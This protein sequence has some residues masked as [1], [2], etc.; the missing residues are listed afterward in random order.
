MRQLAAILFADMAGY[1]A[2]MQENEQLARQKRNRLKSV[3]ES[4]V[5][6]HQGQILQYYGDGSLSIFASAINAVQCA[7]SI[8]QQ[9]REAP[10]VDLRIG[11]HTGDV[12]VEDGSI[13]GDGVNLASRVESLAVPGSVFISEKVYDEIRNQENITSHELGYFELKNVKQPV[14]IFAITSG[15]LVIPSRDE[16][17]GKTKQP[18]NRLAVLPFVNMSADAENEYFSD[19]ITEELL[20]ALTKVD[21]LQVTSR[22]S[23]YAFKGKNDDIRDIAVKL[24]VDKVLEGSVRK[25]GSRVRI[26]AQLINAADGYHL[27]S[28]TYDRQL[29]DIFEVQDEIS[30]I[31]AN[32][33]RENLSRAQ[34]ESQ[35]SKAPTQNI[36]AYTAYLQGLHFFNKTTPADLRKSIERFEEALQLEPGYAQAYAMIATAYSQLGA[37]GQLTPHKA[38]ALVH[39]YAAKALQLDSSIA[40]IYIAEAGA[41]LFYEWKWKETYESLQKAI[42]LNPSAAAA[43]PLLG[44]YHVLMGEKAQAVAILEDAVK[45]DPLSPAINHA[46]GNMYVFAERYDDAIRQA[47]KLLDLNTHI[48]QNLELK[49]WATGMKG[50]WEEACRL[51]EEVYRLTNHPLKGLMGLGYA[52]AKLG[53]TEKAMECI[54]KMEQRQREE[55]DVVLDADFVG[56]WFALGNLEKVFYYIEQCVA[57]RAVPV[58]LFLQYPVFRGL[59]GDPRLEALKLKQ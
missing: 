48:R 15:G 37:S 16:I 49:A 53:Q 19:G 3:L 36:A 8:Q 10:T 4:T 26:T 18:S 31:I 34:R 2:L 45:I 24:N 9:L 50:D 21:G 43:Y 35:G 7:V 59:A 11:I 57:K 44:Y 20:N 27:W 46:L 13:Y 54:R 42:H 30:G 38:F 14:R 5:H 40:E 51:F 28:E 1:T 29:T 39:E 55:P 41:Y 47:N 23:A 12:T 33:L 56:V 32:K 58:N 22:T 52:Y 25:A 6:L 17:R